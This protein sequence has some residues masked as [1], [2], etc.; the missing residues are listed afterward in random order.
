[1]DNLARASKS[2]AS[3]DAIAFNQ[4]L[5]SCLA[6][7]HIEI[8]MNVYFFEIENL[9]MPP[10]IVAIFAKSA[11]CAS[12]ISGRLMH[13]IEQY[14]PRYSGAGLT[15]FRQSGKP[16]QLRDALASGADE[17]LGGYT[18]EGGWTVRAVGAATVGR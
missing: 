3:S 11:E 5:S 13:N 15:L 12:V 6:G 17:G 1:M 18:L 10:T 14:E 7:E 9:S 2:L 16:E 4:P 8:I